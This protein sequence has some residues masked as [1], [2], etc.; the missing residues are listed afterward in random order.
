MAREIK[1]I[2]ME[3]DDLTESEAEELMQETREM[4]NNGDFD[5][6]QD[7]LGLEDD[8]IFDLLF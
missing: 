5:A 1:K 7:M 8:Y 3:R 6:M 2:L 4:L